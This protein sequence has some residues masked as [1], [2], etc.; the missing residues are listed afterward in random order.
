MQ[1]STNQPTMNA[2]NKKSDGYINLKVVLKDA[3]GVEHALKAPMFGL[4]KS[5]P[6]H[7][8]I[9]KNPALAEHMVVTIDSIR[10]A[11][12]VTSAEDIDLN[13]ASQVESQA[14]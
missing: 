3:S 10:A 4:D 13:F 7:A 1:Q 6:L 14:S 12:P 9:I 8:A 2:R 5:I 11:T